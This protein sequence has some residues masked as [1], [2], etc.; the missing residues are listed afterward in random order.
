MTTATDP[1]APAGA[2]DAQFS[3]HWSTAVAGFVFVVFA[4]LAQ[5]WFTV[6]PL[7]NVPFVGKGGRWARRKQFIQGKGYQLY[8]DGYRQVSWT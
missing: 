3:K 8:I 6:D 4:L 7:A 5:S 1:V 2:F